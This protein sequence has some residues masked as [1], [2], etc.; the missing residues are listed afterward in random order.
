MWPERFSCLTKATCSRCDTETLFSRL[1]FLVFRRYVLSHPSTT[2]LLLVYQP[3]DSKTNR[4][5]IKVRISGEKVDEFPMVLISQPRVGKCLRWITG[6]FPKSRTQKWF[7]ENEETIRLRALEHSWRYF[8][9]QKWRA[10]AFSFVSETYEE[11]ASTS[12]V[13]TKPKRS[14]CSHSNVPNNT[15]RPNVSQTVQDQRCS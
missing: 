13:V 6:S 7:Q 12:V 2:K 15:G 11:R 10:F 9:F 5:L 8:T 3:D 1:W 14:Q 4:S